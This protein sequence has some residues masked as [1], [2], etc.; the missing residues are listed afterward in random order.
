V[1]IIPHAAFEFQQ[2][3]RVRALSIPRHPPPGRRRPVALRHV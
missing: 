3:A 2:E 1:D